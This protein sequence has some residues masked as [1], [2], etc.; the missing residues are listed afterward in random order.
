MDKQR[1]QQVKL[2][3]RQV[4]DAYRKEFEVATTTAERKTY[5]HDVGVK[6][7][8]NYR[9]DGVPLLTWKEAHEIIDELMTR[10]TVSDKAGVI[11]PCKN[12]PRVLDDYEAKLVEEREARLQQEAPI[13]N[14]PDTPGTIMVPDGK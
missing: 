2:M 1:E 10:P 5:L 14:I 7:L 9:E 8:L 12:P 6:F 4:Y 13:S 11:V 3:R